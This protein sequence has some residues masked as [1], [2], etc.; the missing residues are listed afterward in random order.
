MPTDCICVS[1]FSHY[2]QQLFPNSIN[3]YIFVAETSLSYKLL[4]KFCIYYLK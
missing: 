1:Y 2:K 3:Q 4:S